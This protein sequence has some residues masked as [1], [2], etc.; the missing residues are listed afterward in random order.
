MWYGRFG[1]RRAGVDQPETSYLE[2]VGDIMS[3]LLFVFILTMAVFAILFQQQREALAETARAQQQAI[4]E[5]TQIDN[6]RK[7]LLESL[8]ASLKER[9]VQIQVDPEQG[10]LRLPESILFLSGRADLTPAGERAVRI[11]AEELSLVLPCYSAAP[12]DGCDPTTAGK[13]DVVLIE[14]HT[15]NVPI[16]NAPFPDNWSLSAAR[17]ITTY[18]ALVRAAPDLV[19]L[20][21]RRGVPIFGV[22]GYADQRPVADNR[23]E[24]GKRLNRRIDLRFIMTAPAPEVVEPA[25]AGQ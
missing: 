14:G 13:L 3:G 15:D 1:S 21:N 19:Q 5:L 17:S 20:K 8:A 25:S 23:T 12:P 4:A 22:A 18:Q 9:G 2:S 24:A 7:R 11:L 6:M 16:R 10:V